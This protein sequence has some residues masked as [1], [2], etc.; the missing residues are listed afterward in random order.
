MYVRGDSRNLHINDCFYTTETTE[1]T[2]MIFLKLFKLFSLTPFAVC[3]CMNSV[4]IEFISII[5]KK[6]IIWKKFPLKKDDFKG[7]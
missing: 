3:F 5:N 7:S 2:L 6:C 1:Y 4:P